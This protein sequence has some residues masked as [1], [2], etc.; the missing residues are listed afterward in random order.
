M[1]AGF[2][3][4]LQVIEK[5]LVKFLNICEYLGVFIDFL[6]SLLKL[7]YACAFFLYFFINFFQSFQVFVINLCHKKFKLFGNRSKTL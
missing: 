7:V 1:F 6:N 3:K 5:Y 2:R 4:F